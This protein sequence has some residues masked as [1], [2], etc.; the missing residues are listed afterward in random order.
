MRGVTNDLELIAIATDNNTGI[1]YQRAGQE[2]VVVWI[3][4]YGFR[5][6]S[7]LNQLRILND[8]TRNY[9]VLNPVIAACKPFSDL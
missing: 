4:A 6:I 3:L 8:Q 7:A 5:Q 1:A 9:F 2:L